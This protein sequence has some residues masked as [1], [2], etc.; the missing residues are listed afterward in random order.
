MLSVD[1]NKISQMAKNEI[2]KISKSKELELQKSNA[3]SVNKFV[4]SFK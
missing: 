3:K 2:A 4:F 1:Y